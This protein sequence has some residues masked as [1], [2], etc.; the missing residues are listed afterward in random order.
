MPPKTAVGLSHHHRL[1]ER[2]NC[3]RQLRLRFP[4]EAAFPDQIPTKGRQRRF[5]ILD[6]TGICPSGFR[7]RFS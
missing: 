6:A 7:S 4:P 3:Q 2:P 1:Q 5:E